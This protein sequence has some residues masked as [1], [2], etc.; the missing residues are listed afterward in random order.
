[1]KALLFTILISPFCSIG[2]SLTPE[3]VSSSGDFHSTPSAQLSWT[4]G[5]IAIDTYTSSSNQLTQGFHQPE[6]PTVSLTSL[7]DNIR[8]NA[9]PNPFISSIS[10][11][12]EDY[13]Q[14]IEIVI[15]N[16]VGQEVHSDY[17]S[18]SEP[19]NINLSAL[20][21]GSYLIQ[22]KTASDFIKTLKIQKL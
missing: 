15:Y 22:F 6:R 13:N 5:E 1:M 4:L 3:V 12:I 16:A 7:N 20:E 2:Q 17:Y 18:G 11:N 14:S 21:S 9:Y 10:I 19:K 8:I